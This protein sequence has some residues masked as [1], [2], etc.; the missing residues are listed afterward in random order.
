MLGSYLCE[1]FKIKRIVFSFFK[2]ETNK[3]Y[4]IR[5]WPTELCNLHGWISTW[6]D[7]YEVFCI[8]STTISIFLI[9]N[10]FF[11]P[12]YHFLFLSSS[13]LRHRL[14]ARKSQVALAGGC[15]LT[16]ISVLPD[17]VPA[18][19]TIENCNSASLLYERDGAW[20]AVIVSCL[21]FGDQNNK[22]IIIASFS[23]FF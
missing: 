15:R 23:F 18:V 4:I 11:H 5:S 7:F 2:T 6:F 14:A 21:D 13:I 22:T 12:L 16:P 3:F 19:Y 1:S 20:L 9:S 17:S 10:F 8:C